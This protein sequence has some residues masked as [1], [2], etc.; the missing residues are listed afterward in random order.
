MTINHD[1]NKIQINETID[2]DANGNVLKKGL[3]I[4][5]RSDKVSEAESLYRQIKAK[6]NGQNN[7]V[8]TGKN[9]S[10]PQCECGNPMILRNGKKGPFYGCAAF[11]Q[12][13]NTKELN[14]IS[15]EEVIVEEEPQG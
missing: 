11:P 8:P 14:E 15:D 13:R 7:S 10:V 9:D 3:M 12:C 4:N 6:L 2:K 5:I 1:Y